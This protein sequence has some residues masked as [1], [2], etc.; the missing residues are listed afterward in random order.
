MNEDGW[1]MNRIC[2]EDEPMTNHPGLENR[3]MRSTRKTIS[4]NPNPIRE[5]RE[6]HTRLKE[7]TASKKYTYPIFTRI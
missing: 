7:H 6:A 3:C 1:G 2:I 5:I 4:L